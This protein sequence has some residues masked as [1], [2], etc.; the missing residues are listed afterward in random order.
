MLL[1]LSLS[2]TAYVGGADMVLGTSSN[3][4]SGE[5]PSFETYCVRAL[6]SLRYPWYWRGLAMLLFAPALVSPHLLARQS[7]SHNRGYKAPGTLFVD[8][9]DCAS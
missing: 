6:N 7:A 4:T 1:L 9:I 3:I 5:A 2:S 8:R